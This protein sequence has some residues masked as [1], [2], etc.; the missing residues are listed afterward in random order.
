MKAAIV[1]AH[2]DDE[3]LWGAGW[4]LTHPEDSFAIWC[5]STP[6]IDPARADRFFDACRV[7]DSNGLVLVGSD[8]PRRPLDLSGLYGVLDT[9]DYVV[10]H[11]AVGEYQNEHHKQVHRYVAENFKG[12]IVNFGRGLPNA[13]IRIKLTDEQLHTKLRA[14]QRYSHVART[15]RCPKWRA[16]LDRYFNNDLTRFG[17]ETYVQFR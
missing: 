9:Y 2:P 10:T 15:D 16:L 14:L 4:I 17:E 6:R 12:P 3:V 8:H 7:L 13:D 1:V 11:N 5:C